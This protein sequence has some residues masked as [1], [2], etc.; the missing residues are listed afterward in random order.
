M[1]GNGR[2]RP[3]TAAQVIGNVRGRQHRLSIHAAAHSLSFV[4]TSTSMPVKSGCTA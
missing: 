4:P 3:P 2:V 1:D